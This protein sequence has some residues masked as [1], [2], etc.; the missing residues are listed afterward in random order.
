VH[1]SWAAQCASNGVARAGEVARRGTNPS[2]GSSL[3]LVKCARRGDT[4]P[5]PLGCQTT[6]PPTKAA[7]SSLE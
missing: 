2:A 4:L 7:L 3:P 1:A 5:L 6:R